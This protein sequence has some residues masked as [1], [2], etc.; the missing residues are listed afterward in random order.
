LERY[1]AKLREADFVYLSDTGLP[2]ENQVVL[3]CG[4]RGLALFD[5]HVTGP[6]GDLH[7]G[8]HGGVLR[9]PIQ[10]LTEILATLHTPDGRVNIPGFY[11]A[12]LD[13]HPWER[14]ELRK[15]GGDEK[16]YARFLGIE[17]F[18]TTQGIIRSRRSDS[19]PRWKSTASEADIKGRAQRPS[20]PAKHSP[21]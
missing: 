13:V 4:L 20:F 10:A 8:L 6:K 21:N 18:Y 2:N 17:T 5:V 9:N 16:A 12:V 3:T 11:E 15:L 14:D 7:S 19:N 1:A